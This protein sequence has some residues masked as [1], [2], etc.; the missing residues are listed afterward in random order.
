MYLVDLS[1][2]SPF[3]TSGGWPI[4]KFVPLARTNLRTSC[5]RQYVDSCLIDGVGCHGMLAKDL[6]VNS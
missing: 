6:G 2:S 5:R 3:N 4:R 1:S